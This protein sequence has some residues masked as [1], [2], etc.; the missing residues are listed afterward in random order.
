MSTHSDTQHGH[1]PAIEPRD[2]ERQ[3]VSWLLRTEYVQ[4][5]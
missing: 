1:R 2:W 4:K 5:R 3:G